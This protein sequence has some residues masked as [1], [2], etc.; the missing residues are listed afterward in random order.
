[1]KHLTTLLLTLLILGGCV[2]NWALYPRNASPMIVPDGYGE[3]TYSYT[4]TN[5][6]YIHGQGV[7]T[8]KG[9]TSFESA[10]IV[11]YEG[12]FINSNWSGRGIATF[13]NGDWIEADWE[14]WQKRKENTGGICYRADTGTFHD[15]I[16]YLRGHY[17]IDHG[18]P[19][20]QGD[21]LMGFGRFEDCYK[22]DYERTLQ[23]MCKGDEFTLNDLF[24]TTFKVA[25]GAVLVAGLVAISP[26]GQAALANKEAQNQRKREAAAYKKGREDGIRKAARKKRNLCNVDPTYC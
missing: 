23:L 5:T 10:G 16:P 17:I 9:I 25:A 24:K 15:I 2:A 3:Q 6:R 11:S 1:M 12:E 19:V 18:A 21:G 4:E 13:D 8:N 14:F 7:V 20:C 26:A 22:K